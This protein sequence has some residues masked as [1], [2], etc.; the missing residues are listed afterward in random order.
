LYNETEGHGNLLGHLEAKV[1]DSNG[2]PLQTNTVGSLFTKGY[3]LKGTLPATQ[4]TEWFAT[5]S[6][7]KMN[8]QGQFVRE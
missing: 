5:G 2:K 1:A 8:D 7:S 4:Q 3:H 6:S